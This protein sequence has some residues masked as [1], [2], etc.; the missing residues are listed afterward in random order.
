MI[1]VNKFESMQIGLA[2]PDKIRMW[3]YGEVKKPETIN[4]RTLKPEKDGLFDERI[5]GP[6]KDYECACGKYKRIRYKGIVCDRCG[7]EVTKSKVRRERMGHIELA[8]P[9]THIW[10]FKGIPSRMGLVLDMSPRS[11]EEII[12]F[13]S[14]VVVD[15][16][17]TPLE[18][19][20]LLTE[21]EYRAKL[22][23]YGNRFVA[24]IG[25]EAIQAL[26]Q[27][28]DLEKEADLLKEE[29]KEASGQKRTR[30]VRRLDIIEAFIKSGNHPDWMVMDAIPVIPPDLRPMVQLDGGRFATSD[31]NDLYRRV[32]NRNNRLKRLLDLNAPGIIVQNEKRMLQEAVDAL[33]DN[34]RRGRPVAGPGNRPLKSLSHM[35]KGKQGR[36]RQNL[37]GKRVDYSGRSVIDVGPSL[38]MNQM[39]L[40]VP[41]AME[42]FKPFIMKELVSRNLASNI[43][44]AK[45]KIDRKDEEV[46]D[47]LE[48]VIKEHPVLLN[49]APTL[50]R[51]G[52]QAFEPVLVSGKAM[53][54]HPLACEAYNADFDGDQMAIHVP[55]SNE[56]QAEARLLMLAAHHILAPKDGKPVVT[57][58]QDMVIGNYWLTMERAESVG[59]G[60]IFNDLDEVKLAL[61]NGYVSIHTR[62]GVR[63]SSMPE[64]PFTDQQRQ[65]ILITTAGKMLFNDILPKDFVYL[66]APTNENLVNGTP[67]E[68][69]LEAGEDIHEQLNQRPLLSPFKSGFLSD[70][71]AEV[72][73]QYKVTET[74][75]LLDRMKDLGFYRSTLSGLTVGIAD[76]TNLP[77]K[78]TIIAAAH[79]KVATVTKQFRR[80]LITDDERYERVIGIWNDAKDEIQQRLMD[81]FDPQNPIFMMS[82]S[83][84]RGNISNF[85]QLAGMRGLM[86]A[87]NGKIM[88][89]PILS[90]FREGLSVLEMFIST[91]GARKGMTDTALKTANSGYL[92]RR[93]VDVAQDVIV[94]EKDCGTDRGLLITAIAEGNEMIEPLYDRILGRYTMKSVINPETGKV[95]V[96]QNEMIDERSAQ[97]IIDA[98]IQEVTI[99]SAFTCNTAHG[100]CEKCYGR[101]MATGDRVEV[102]EAVGTVAAQSIGEPGTQLTMR[103][104]HTGGV[105]GNADIT[106]GLPRIQEI[107][108]ARNP[109]GPAEISEVTGVVESIEEDP[110]E[111]TK[112]VTVKGETDTRT[113]SLPITARMKVAEGDYIHRGAPL[114][115]GSIDPKKLIKVRDVLSTENYLLS[116]IQKVYRMQGIEISDK[117]VE[118]MIRQMLRK[119]RV[120]D[121]G[122][123]D[124]LPGTLMDIDDF[125]KDNYKTLIAGGIPATS[126][127]VILGIT[128][129]ALETNSFLSAAS[130]QETT[131]VLTDAAIRGKNDPL[132]G[133]KENVIIGKIIPAGTGMTDYRQ[134]KPEVVGGNTEQPQTLSDVEKE[135]NET[136]EN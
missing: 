103:N 42:L 118:I 133:L 8:A 29:L 40:P 114:N 3:S 38:K 94:R 17:D 59:E 84:A 36:F 60:M 23:E 71:I 116:E 63:A 5:F 109:K 99:R 34:G 97:E 102:G 1:D 35:L 6:T 57:P 77:D 27:S 125:K 43:K 16:G 4:Y 135:M 105:A 96:G 112:E 48:D 126:R 41:M 11:L 58:S 70:V 9:V 64:K 66:N 98:G 62:I 69:F 93:L 55:L 26:L 79:K 47:V 45:R 14:Y 22:D 128:K 7:V 19:K 39:G 37:L 117:H 86:A 67:D 54:L 13:A 130:F 101:N 131:R 111:G 95:I 88:E 15:P 115:E 90:N 123:T 76:I 81:T 50:H 61:Q 28:V 30:A 136:I 121:P 104:F 106:Q 32:I 75:L 12:Y 82:D 134:I 72:Y 65:Q 53:R 56:A 83:G 113:Y 107:V 100:V 33:I 89:L 10:Y 85:T 124:I 91:H 129:A 108:E 31:L 110:A 122:D 68:Y 92:T 2:S 78:P 49:R 87:P 18:K 74:S 119:V 25:G 120:M 80:G 21:R 127:P 44:N 46:Y 20:Q 52:I 73:K 132:V 51:L 24:K